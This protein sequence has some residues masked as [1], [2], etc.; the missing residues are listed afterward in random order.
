MSTILRVASQSKRAAG[1]PGIASTF[2]AKRRKWEE[3]RACVDPVSPFIVFPTQYLPYVSH[4]PVL[5]VKEA[6]K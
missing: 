2:Q 3:Q 1:A 4:W 6:G 5:S